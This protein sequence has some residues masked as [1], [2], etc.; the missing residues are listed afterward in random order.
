MILTMQKVDQANFTKKK[1]GHLTSWRKVSLEMQ[2]EGTMMDKHPQGIT[3]KMTL[4]EL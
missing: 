1:S 3:K 2:K 4:P